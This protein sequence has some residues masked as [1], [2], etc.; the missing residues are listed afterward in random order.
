MHALANTRCLCLPS[1]KVL[2]LQVIH[3]LGLSSGVRLPPPPCDDPDEPSASSDAVP[4][5]TEAWSKGC[6][7]SWLGGR[8]A[9]HR[10]PAQDDLSVDG[11]E[12]QQ[13]LGCEDEGCSRTAWGA[14][15]CP[16][17]H[18][19]TECDDARALE[20]ERLSALALDTPLH[21]GAADHVGSDGVCREAESDA[22]GDSLPTHCQLV[23]VS[24]FMADHL[25]QVI[26]SL[27]TSPGVTCP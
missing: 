12:A 1:L 4:S 27:P 10:V 8:A 13:L 14:T 2:R 25:D 17:P 16:C 26:D 7:A 11:D 24:A 23:G 19:G 6:F 5:T 3:I 9:S 21:A 15:A 20:G 18:A 22:R